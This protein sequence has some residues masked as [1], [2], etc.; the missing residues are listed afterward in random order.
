MWSGSAPRKGV[1]GQLS[2]VGSS[3]AGSC[4]E[5]SASEQAASFW[6]SSPGSWES[7]WDTRETG[8]SLFSE[9]KADERAP[10]LETVLSD[11]IHFPTE[12]TALPAAGQLPVPWRTSSESPWPCHS[13]GDGIPLFLCCSCFLSTPVLIDLGISSGCSPRFS[14]RHFENTPLS[15]VFSIISCWSKQPRSHLSPWS[16]FAHGLI[17]TL[18]KSSAYTG[19][20]THPV[21]PCPLTEHLLGAR[22]L[23]SSEQVTG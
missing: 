5:N 19:K 2:R 6:S 17:V 21:T 10:P 8:A 22:P 1:R 15:Y 9:Q 18:L 20:H 4:D 13:R 7:R 12:L 14:A 3:R 11:S 16:P 23:C